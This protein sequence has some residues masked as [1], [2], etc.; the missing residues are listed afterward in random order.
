[1]P[2]RFTIDGFKSNFRDGQKS[3]LFYFLPNFPQDTI[4]GD[5][6]NDRAVYLVRATNLPTTTLEETVLPWQGMDFPLAMK[7]TYQAFTVTFNCDMNT[8]IRQNFEK[9]I[10]KIHNPVTNRYALINEYMLDQRLQLLANDGKVVLEFV[11]HDAWPMEVGS[12]N[13]SYD[14]AE[15]TQFDVTFRYSYHLMYDKATGD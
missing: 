9:W 10:N 12:A 4:T 1:M 8:R 6:N 13:L 5:M 3:N 15:I 14:A 7:H 2:V 11:L